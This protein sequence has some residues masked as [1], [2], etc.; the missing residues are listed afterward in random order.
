[1]NRRFQDKVVLV[2]GAGSGIGRA[3]AHMFAAE[4]ARVG[5]LDWKESDAVTAQI[6]AAGGQAIALHADIAQ[7]GE[8]QAAV[9]ALMAAYGRLDVV[10]ANAGI[11]GVQAPIDEIEP[12]EWDQV[13]AVNLRGVYLTFHYTVPYLKQQGGAMVITSSIQGTRSFHGPGSTA[14][15]CCKAAQVAFAKKMALELAR[16]RIRVNVICP[17]STTTRINES[18]VV[19]SREKIE[20]P[21]QFP[22][23]KVLLTGGV[24]ATPEQIAKSVLFLA[25]EDADMITGSELWVDGVQSLFYG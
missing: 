2:T 8:M 1:M 9:E 22:K 25:S 12:E 14:Y 18:G 4:G 3:A 15:A 16:Y 11:N 24:K 10:F 13:I 7:A 20:L 5:V 6:A 17:G 19:R 21:A 23:G